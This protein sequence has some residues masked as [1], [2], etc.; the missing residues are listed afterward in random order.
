MRSARASTSSS[1]VEISRIADPVG[2]GGTQ[3]LGHVLDG[4]DIQATRRLRGNQHARSGRQLA[5]QHGALL[6][7]TGQRSHRRVGRRRRMIE[8]GDQLAPARPPCAG[9]CTPFLLTAARSPSARFSATE[10]SSTQPS[11]GDP[12]GSR[13]RRRRQRARTCRCGMGS[14]HDQH[15]DRRPAGP[16]W[17]AR[18][19]AVAGR[20]PRPRRARRSRRREPWIG[21]VVEQLATCRRRRR[22]RPAPASTT[23][24]RSSS[25][26][27]A[28]AASVATV[29]MRP[30]AAASDRSD[31]GRPTIAW[32][33]AGGRGRR[34]WPCDRPR[35]LRMIVTSSVAWRISSS[36]CDTSA[37]RPSSTTTVRTHLEEL[38]ALLRR[39]HAGRLVEHDD[40]QFTTQAPDDLGALALAS[41]QRRDDG[42]WVDT[43]AVALAEAR[44]HAR[45][46]CCGR[47]RPGSPSD[48][49][50]DRERLHQ[51]VVLVHH[52]DA[53]VRRGHRAVD[54]HRLRPA[55]SRRCPRRAGSGRS[56]SSSES[57]CRR[58]SPR[59]PRGCVRVAA[60]R[61]T[62]VACDA[63]DP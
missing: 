49:L 10:R 29:S 39:Q 51:A 44:R 23:A 35:V 21:Q 24:D 11:R 20:C 14:P 55:R 18:R 32:A 50:P 12:R 26:S 8:L 2:G 38:L 57:T 59:A 48:V 6:V 27:A 16:G 17:R 7:P 5:G 13:R 46:P 19:P 36:L 53:E 22:W 34:R 58:R 63:T 43:E 28:A 33:S 3:P 62:C 9:R 37:A 56:G 45:A 1:S 40:P 15:R 25:S 41:G 52:G 54:G 61:S 60:P 42:E 47:E 31:T 4:S 30:R